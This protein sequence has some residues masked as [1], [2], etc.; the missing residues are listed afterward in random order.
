MPQERRA[1]SQKQP[2][3]KKKANLKAPLAHLSTK[4][5]SLTRRKEWQELPLLCLGEWTARSG[6][7]E[8]N[9]PSIVSRDDLE[10]D[11]SGFFIL[12]NTYHKIAF[13]RFLFVSLRCGVWKNPLTE[14]ISMAFHPCMG[15]FGKFITGETVAPDGWMEDDGFCLATIWELVRVTSLLFRPQ[16]D[17]LRNETK[18]VLGFFFLLLSFNFSFHLWWP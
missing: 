8:G 9:C 15:L 4:F 11:P 2:H 10:T 6:R 13:L 14:M 16:T 7:N 1:L 12:P 17:F 18:T 3:H 5:R